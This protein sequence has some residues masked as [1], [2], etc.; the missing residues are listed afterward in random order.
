MIETYAIKLATLHLDGESHEWWYHVL[1]TLGQYHHIIPR[2]YT[3]A[4][5]A[6]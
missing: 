5:G 2:F 1:V 4:H 6:I 3:E